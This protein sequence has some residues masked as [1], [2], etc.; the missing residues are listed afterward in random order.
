[1]QHRVTFKEC[2]YSQ[3]ALV[4]RRTVVYAAQANPPFAGQGPAERIVAKLSYQVTSRTAEDELIAAARVKGVPHIPTVY[5]RHDLFDIESLQD[6]IRARVVKH[7]GAFYNYENRVA[8]IIVVK[9]Y[10]PL[11]QRL[12]KHPRDLIRM[13]DEISECLHRL[14]HDAKILHRD[15]SMSNIMCDETGGRADFILTD[16]DLAVMLN[17]DG[18]PRGPTAKHRTGTLPFMARE[19]LED[20]ALHPGD[21]HVLHELHH[22]YESLFWVALW[23]T[24]RVDYFEEPKLQTRIDDFLNQWEFA[25]GQSKSQAS[26][27]PSNASRGSKAQPETT[28]T[29]KISKLNLCLISQVKTSLLFNGK[30]DRKRPPVTKRFKH[31][32][33]P[34]LIREFRLLILNAYGRDDTDSDSDDDDDDDDDTDDTD[35]DVAHDQT[36]ANDNTGKD[37]TGKGH[38]ANDATGNDHTYD[39]HIDHN[40]SQPGAFTR[41]MA[42]MRKILTR[43]AIKTVIQNV[44]KVVEQREAEKAARKE[45]KAAEKAAREEKKAAKKAARK[46]K[47]AAKKAARKEKRAAKKAARK[48]ETA[49]G[50]AQA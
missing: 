4:G 21:P 44:M 40:A 8:R 41:R 10:T 23:C 42:P 20:L 19:L 37:H 3:Y 28:S 33:I 46:E 15:V 34:V 25:K 43:E 9:M 6:G 24:M 36:D 18:T 17:D 2:V 22:D 50:R 11:K 38:T 12:H 27:P 45:K 35:S 7:C 47:R 39:D 49:A 14:R 16:F 31:F 48:E 32:G 30:L 13:V 29:T 1:M 5:G 26:Q